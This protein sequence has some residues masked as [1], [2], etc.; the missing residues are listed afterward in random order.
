M[1][2]FYVRWLLSGGFK[3]MNNK[4]NKNLPILLFSLAWFLVNLLQSYFTEIHEDEAYYWVFSEFPAWGYFDHPPMIAILV[5]MGYALFQNELGVRLFPSILGAGTIFITYKLLPFQYREIRLYILLVSTISLM[6]INVAGFM[7]LPDIPLVFFTCLYFLVLKRY[8]VEDKIL[9]AIGLGIIIALMM[10]SKYHALLILFF[11]ILSDWR[12]VLRRT[13]WMIAAIS[14]LF[15]LPHI[16]WQ[17][18]N[19]FVSFQYHLVDRSASFQM[20]DILAYIGNQLLVTGP[21]IGFL[22][23]YL[24]FSRHPADAFERMLKFILYGFFGFFLLSS[25]RGHVEPHWTAAAFPVLIILAVPQ[26]QGKLKLRKLLVILGFATLP[27]VLVLRLYLMIDFLPMPEHVS[28]M[29]HQKDTWVEQIEAAAGDRPVIFRNKFQYPSLYR[30]YTGKPAFTRNSMYYRRN[31]YDVWN[32]EDELRGQEVFLTG[33]G[34]ME[35]IDTLKTVFGEVYFWKIDRYCSFN[36]LR[37]KIREER[38]SAEP[39]DIISI[40]VRLENPNAYPVCL[41]CPCDIPPYLIAVFSNDNGDYYFSR[42]VD[43][44]VL[45]ELKPGEIL[46]LTVR[47]QIPAPAGHYQMII[48]FRSKYLN[49]GINGKP[50]KFEITVPPGQV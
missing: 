20:K 48:A 27:I 5:K 2:Y 21:L 45:S 10:Y 12:L 22:L 43:D 23:L 36:N 25:V 26:L 33:Y 47:I 16:I 42:M 13:F 35:G 9:Q 44:P 37:L 7:A 30:F 18:K 15:Y 11:T 41:D 24:A 46:E 34:G 50:V 32:M 3:N 28:R 1:S 8:L 40:P 49:P 29:F 38:F 17:F 4:L 19:D 31:Q 6:H 39:G 14:I